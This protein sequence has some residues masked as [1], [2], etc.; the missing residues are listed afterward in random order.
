LTHFRVLLK[1]RIWEI[2][3]KLTSPVWKSNVARARLSKRTLSELI[4]IFGTS[5][6]LASLLFGSLSLPE[7]NGFVGY[8][9]LG[10]GI[11]TYVRVTKN[12]D[13]QTVLTQAQASGYNVTYTRA[14]DWWQTG[15][16]NL[17]RIQSGVAAGGTRYIS[18]KYYVGMNETFDYAFPTSASIDCPSNVSD[19]W[20][21]L[22]LQGLFPQ[23][24]ENECSDFAKQLTS[25]YNTINIS[26]SPNWGII[27]DY[28]GTFR[29]VSCVPIGSIYE[30]YSNGMIEYELPSV[31]ISKE[32]TLTWNR[33]VVFIVSAN[34][35]GFVSVNV[36]SKYKLDKNW[37]REVFAEMFLDIGLPADAISFYSIYENWMLDF[38]R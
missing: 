15:L 28:L 35:L 32:M 22:R 34:G 18:I 5:C 27:G 1:S 4:I 3:R 30:D 36:N 31:T 24:T 10:D 29:S 16:P 2:V 8:Y 26:G 33:P 25:G 11:Q 9:G 20:T 13:L 37:I 38:N 7:I 21:K 6:V 19:E 12:I 17:S 14:I 23:L